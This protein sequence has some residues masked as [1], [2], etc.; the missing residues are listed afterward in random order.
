MYKLLK[1]ISLLPALL[2]LPAFSETLVNPGDATLIKNGT[3]FTENI[4]TIESEY[5]GETIGGAVYNEGVLTLLN[6]TFG[7]SAELA[8]TAQNGG[9]IYNFLNINSSW[10]VVAPAEL[11]VNVAT[12]DSNVSEKRGG[13]I[14]NYGTTRIDGATFTRNHTTG[15]TW[16]AQG[17]AIFNSG[18]DDYWDAPVPTMVISNTTF[19]DANDNTMGN[20][21]LHG[22]AIANEHSLSVGNITL[23]NVNFYYNSAY[24]DTDDSDGYNSTL[25]GAIWNQGEMIVNGDTTFKGNTATGY[26]VTGGAIYNSGKLTFND[27]VVFDSNIATDLN[28]GDGAYGGALNNAYS[29][30]VTFKKFA[31][32]INNKALSSETKYTR[33]GAVNNQNEM[34]FENGALFS[35]NEAVF[36]G[37]IYNED[38]LTFGTGTYTFTGNNAGLGGAIFNAEG[39]ITISSATFGGNIATLG[40]TA[41]NGGAVYNRDTFTINNSIFTNNV[42]TGKGGAIYNVDT[43]TIN[44]STFTHNTATANS[45]AIAQDSKTSMLTLNNVDFVENTSDWG[46]A[47]VARGVVDITNGSFVGNTSN[48]GGGAIYLALLGNKGH[49]LNIN[50]TT[51]TNNSTAGVDVDGGGAIGSFSNL[52]L[53]NAKFTSNHV[54]GTASNGGGAIFMGSESTNDLENITFVKNKSA[55]NGGA[56]STRYVDQG[57]NVGATLNIQGAT[58]TSNVATDKGGAIYNTFHNDK[59]DNGYVMLANTIY[60]KNTAAN[61]GAIYNEAAGTTDTTGGVMKLVVTSFTNNIAH[62]KGGAI[63]NA[64]IMTLSNTN[65]F[66]GNMAKGVANDIHNVGSLTFG[67]SSQTIMDGGITGNG[68]MV[69]AEAAR[70]SIGTASITQGSLTLDGI[71]NAT[72]V[73]TKEYATFNVSDEF[74]GNGTLNLTLKGVGEYNV[75]TASVFDHEHVNISDSD[76]LTYDWNNAYDTIIV[77]TKS[78]EEIVENTGVE[79]ETINPVVNMANSESDGLKDLANKMLDKLAGSDA[80]KA[81]V[82]GAVKTIHPETEAVVQSVA[83]SVQTTVGNL[84][85]SRMSLPTMGRAGGD[86]E[87]TGAGFWANGLYNKSKQNGLFTGYTRGFAIGMDANFNKVLT[88]GT[89]YSYAHSN[90][91]ATHRGT[92]IDSYTMFIYGQYK[93]N[94]WYANAVLNYT[95]SDYTEQGSALGVDVIADYDVRAYGMRLATGYD[96]RNG[97]TPEFGLRYTHIDAD[98]YKNNLGIKNS[99]ESTDYM[100]LT[101][102]GKYARNFKTKVRHISLRPEFHG[103]LKYD[104]MSDEQTAVVTMPGVDSYSIAGGRL[105]RFGAELGLGL[106]MKYY[107]ADWT[108]DYDFEIRE[109]YTSHTGRI[110]WRYNF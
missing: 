65:V 96:L 78:V 48:D 72:L 76:M 94:A 25:G 17:G 106:T 14:Y 23:N 89:G 47:I 60:A 42:A 37:A 15:I 81:A 4:A 75:F 32:F 68:S 100:T 12:F 21:A 64:G 39:D 6:S 93:P 97:I 5:S 55:T 86:I 99:L 92:S 16:E 22:G 56:I 10:E 95:M 88:L 66:E 62:S 71:I 26:N 18:D 31:T 102:G 110:K 35:G 87:P 41:T 44:D 91:G 83:T 74:T 59:A 2:V 108:L 34:T 52:I 109:D 70:L 29:A 54:D 33:G 46:G 69:V 40:N 58:F 20:S 24:A 43:L 105:A 51:F 30:E 53:K 101:L 9:A 85:A 19:G 67:T 3:T 27:G 79:A 103:D 84:A 28:S 77:S 82:A 57:N 80:D 107:N 1:G 11:N 7:G 49:T 98:D 63:Y 45:G 50:G 36:G 13:A 38:E 90:I 104:V 8:N 73:N 61:G